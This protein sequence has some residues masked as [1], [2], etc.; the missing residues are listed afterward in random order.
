MLQ[1]DVVA[2]AV[3]ECAFSRSGCRRPPSFDNTAKTRAKV[4]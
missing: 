3:N 1:K 2:N 4:S